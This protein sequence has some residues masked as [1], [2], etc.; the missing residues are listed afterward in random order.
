ME[1]EI[2]RDLSKVMNYFIWRHEKRSND[3]SPNEK[4]PAV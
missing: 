1:I 3:G 4:S 2:K